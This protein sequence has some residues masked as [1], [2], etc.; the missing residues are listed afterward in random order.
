[1]ETKQRQGRFGDGHSN[2]VVVCHYEKLAA[3]R[4]V[5]ANKENLE[6]CYDKL[7]TTVNKLHL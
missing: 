1:M 7:E 6:D 2:S 3:S 4:A 5:T